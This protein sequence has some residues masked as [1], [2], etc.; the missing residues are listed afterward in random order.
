[1]SGSLQTQHLQ[2]PLLSFELSFAYSIPSPRSSWISSFLVIGDMGDVETGDGRHVVPFFCFS[3]SVSGE[4]W[5]GFL[6]T[7]EPFKVKHFKKVGGVA[8][9]SH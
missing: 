6:A 8:D 4:S 3:V 7:V 9:P 2:C 5:D 1:M